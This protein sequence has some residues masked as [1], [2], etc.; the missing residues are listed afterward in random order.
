MNPM[1]LTYFALLA[2]GLFLL[3]LPCLSTRRRAVAAA[4]HAAA[5]LKRRGTNDC[6]QRM[7][8]NLPPPRL[9][10]W[11]RLRPCRRGKQM[12]TGD[13][14]RLMPAQELHISLWAWPLEL[15]ARLW[16][17]CFAPPLIRID[18]TDG[19]Q[20]TAPEDVRKLREAL[21]EANDVLRSMHGIAARE[22]ADTSWP[23]IR[24]RLKQVLERQHLLRLEQGL[25]P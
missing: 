15:A 17:N 23:T 22:G 24:T 7:A 14:P 20:R 1:A 6:M 2:F 11:Q 16:A 25:Y 19:R 18:L 10:W 4:A 12:H 8:A 9:R 3:L 13:G 5:P 21:V